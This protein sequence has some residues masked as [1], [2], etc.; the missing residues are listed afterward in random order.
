ML[1]FAFLICS[2]VAFALGGVGVSYP[3]LNWVSLG[4]AFLVAAALAGWSL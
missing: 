2:L 4:L 3:P 1:A